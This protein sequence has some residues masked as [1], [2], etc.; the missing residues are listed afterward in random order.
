[1]KKLSIILFVTPLVG[2]YINTQPTNII[3]GDAKENK[4]ALIEYNCDN[5]RQISISFTSINKN[6]IKQDIAIINSQGNQPIILATKQVASG[7]LYTNEKY[8][9]KGKGNEAQWTIGKMMPIK[10]IAAERQAKKKVLI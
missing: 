10:C 3:V 9:L 5:N 4:I 6:N 2:C 7:F 8:T 1:M